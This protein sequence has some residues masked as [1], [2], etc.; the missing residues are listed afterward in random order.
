ML[1]ESS[2]FSFALGKSSC[3]SLEPIGHKTSAP[4]ELIFSGV[5][6]PPMGFLL[7]IFITLL[8]LWML[9]LNTF[10]SCLWLSNLMFSMFFNNFKLMLNVSFQ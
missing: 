2:I 6:D 8:F 1:R 5:Q 7:M 3:L 9:I 4:F 10:G